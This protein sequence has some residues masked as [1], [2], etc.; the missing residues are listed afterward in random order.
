M[1]LS[2]DDITKIIEAL[3]KG[4]NYRYCD[5]CGEQEECY[6]CPNYKKTLQEALISFYV[7]IVK[8]VVRKI[9]FGVSYKEDFISAGIL[10]VVKAVIKIN[11]SINDVHSYIYKSIIE[12][13][14]REMVRSTLV[15]IPHS[16]FKKGFSAKVVLLADMETET[17]GQQDIVDLNEIIELIPQNDSEQII[18][19]CTLERGYKDYE[20]AELVHLST[21]RTNQIKHRLLEKLLR[22]LS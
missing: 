21:R 4:N 18:L 7:P 1:E 12:N 14:K 10:G 13:I 15:P 19:K 3:K 22:E 16:A 9:C 8:S 11:E 17:K 6:S 5:I 2:K 20:I